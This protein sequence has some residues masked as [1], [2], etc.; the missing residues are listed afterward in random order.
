MAGSWGLLP[1]RHL[2]CACVCAFVCV[3]CG[4][5]AF[6]SPLIVQIKQLISP[7]S[8]VLFRLPFLAFVSLV[9]ISAYP[10]KMG[11]PNSAAPVLRM[12]AFFTKGTSQA[13]YTHIPP[14][15]STELLFLDLGLESFNVHFHTASRYLI[16]SMVCGLEEWPGASAGQIKS[17]SFLALSL[18][19][20]L[21]VWMGVCIDCIGDPI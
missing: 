11:H 14:V 15:P 16:I 5:E 9:G 3:W 6:R 13:L 12:G 17:R 2:A 8:V 1:T 21:G 19:I 4:L 20:S 10:E 7:W 18:S